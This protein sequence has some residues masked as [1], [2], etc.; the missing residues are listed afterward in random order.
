MTGSETVAIGNLRRLRKLAVLATVL[1]SAASVFA[2]Q[3][4]QEQLQA[5]VTRSLASQVRDDAR[6]DV[7]IER[8]YGAGLDPQK[9]AIAKSS[10][11]ALLANERLPAYLARVL[12]PIVSPSLTPTEGQAYIVE[13]LSSLRTSGLR[14]LSADRQAQYVAFTVNMAA[15]IPAATCKALFLGKLD[16][17]TGG[18]V[19]LRHIAALPLREF[20]AVIQLY[21]DSSEAE[22]AGYPDARI[23]NA[24]EASGADRAYAAAVATRL[25]RLPTGLGDRVLRNVEASEPREACLWFRENLA[26]A[27]DLTDPYRGWYLARFTERM[28]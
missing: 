23:L 5:L 7:A 10:L 17:R 16:T 2:Q 19:E 21:Q 22:L 6:L 4:K 11:R 26:A 24:T 15:S 8:T 3:S 28:Q 14:R 20:E 12:A 1:A 25:Q 9:H 18:L 13:V 27:L